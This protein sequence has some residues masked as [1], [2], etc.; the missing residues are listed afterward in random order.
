[1]NFITLFF[2]DDRKLDDWLSPILVKELRQG[3]RARVF[4]ISFLLL[5]LF[6]IVLVLGNVAAQDDRSTLEFQNNFFWVILGFALLGLMPLRGL[7]AISLEV[8]NHTMETIMLTRLTA[9]RVV[10]GKWSA[11]FAQ[12]LLLVSAVL[13]YVVLRYFIGGDDVVSDF[14]WILFMLWMSGLLIAACIGVSALGNF[15]IRIV[16]LVCIAILTLTAIG[17]YESIGAGLDKAWEIVAWLVVFGFFIS[18][19][20]FE[21]TATGIAPASENHALR[22]RLLALAFLLVAWGLARL[23]QSDFTPG[24]CIP[25]IVLVAVCYFD[26]AEKPRLLPRMVRSMAQRGWPGKIAAIFLLPGWPSAL[27]FSIVVVPFAVWLYCATA[28]LDPDPGWRLPLFST[29]GSIFTP[30]VICHFFWPR[31]KQVL[32]MVFIYNLILFGLG[33]ILGGFADLTHTPINKVLAFLPG[34]PVFFTG[35][36]SDSTKDYTPLCLVGNAITL[37]I[38]LFA[39]LVGSRR[40]FREL[41]ALLRSAPDVKPSPDQPV[42]EAE[43]K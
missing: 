16:I 14:E 5:Q 19:I 25:A 23:A 26:L 3:M 12:S 7:V 1:M 22:L 30:I 24:I 41:L 9:W 28:K 18:A 36:A 35:L 4:V 21:L 37:V 29:F 34:L 32:L 15:V 20:L 6:L 13:P 17:N 42:P 11:L 27:L 8:K 33:S 10:F 43:I 31:N 38:L 40:Y 2:S 39:L